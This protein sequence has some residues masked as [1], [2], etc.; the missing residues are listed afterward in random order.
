MKSLVPENQGLSLRVKL[1]LSY[2]G[3]ALGAILLMVVVVTIAVQSYFYQAQVSQLRAVTEDIAQHMAQ[4]Y[5][6]NR[7]WSNLSL[8]PRGYMLLSYLIFADTHGNLYTPLLPGGEFDPYVPTLEH[9]LSQA[10]QGQEAEGT[11]QGTTANGSPFSA[12]YVSEP[13]AV[14]KQ[15]VGAVILIQPNHYQPGFSPTE[16]LTSV[17]RFILIAGLGIALAVTLFSLLLT[18]RL[19]RPLVSLTLAAEEMKAGNYAQRVEQPKNRDEL[20]R[21]AVT[22]NAMAD[23]IASDVYELRAQEQLRR[24]LIANIAH[25]LVTPLTAIQGYSEAIADDVIS[26]PEERHETAQLIGREVQRLR[27]LVSDMQNMSSL[28]TGRLQLEL[29]PL[30]LYDLV[31]ETLAVIAPECEQAQIELRNSIDPATPAALAD[32]D[33]ITQVLLNLLD[34]ARRHTPAGGSITLGARTEG[35]WL[36]AWVS[37]TGVGISPQDLLYIFERFYRVDRARSVS[38]GGSGLGLAIIKAIITAHGGTVWAQSTPG[39]GTTIFFKLHLIPTL[40]EN[41]RKSETVKV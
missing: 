29:A 26:E 34:N 6:E 30:S 17:N 5:R 35:T 37:D 19:T 8:R 28:E 13:I 38:S 11:L 41:V 24:D 15:I 21:L 20:G 31:T 2:L 10:L 33:R 9:A 7:S 27:R 16:V 12:I 23:K 1:V 40:P 36:V 25:D 32:S 39:Q 22:F 18:R 4:F 14:D 3:V